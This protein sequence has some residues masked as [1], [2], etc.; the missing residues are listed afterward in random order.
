MSSTLISVCPRCGRKVGGGELT[1]GMCGELL[2]REGRVSLR[3]TALESHPT[4]AEPAPRSARI[5]LTESA[6]VAVVDSEPAWQPWAYLG[7]GIVTAPVFGLTPILQYMGWFLASLVHEMGHAAVAWLCGMSAIPAISLA[8]HAAAVHQEQSKF[9]VALLGLGLGWAG[10]KFL[11]GAWRWV[12]LALVA[13]I[14]PAIAFTDAKELVHLAA[15][16]GG[17]LVF[18]TLCLWKALDGGFTESRTERALYGTVGW[19][20]LGRNL[21]LFVGL[22]RSAAARAEYQSSGSFGLTND[23]IRIAED[24]LDWRLESVAVLMVIAS[25][26]VLPA[27]IGFWRFSLACRRS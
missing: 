17:E 1:C 3:S 6:P 18:A 15:G 21:F 11:A 25:V 8:G 20:L 13:I 22:A 26:L 12:A 7:V 14:Y 9:L 23:F 24:V 2:R 19:Y 16:H 10:W 5:A 27:A 4:H